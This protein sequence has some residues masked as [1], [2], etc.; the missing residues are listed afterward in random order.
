MR[1]RYLQLGQPGLE[2]ALDVPAAAG[3]LEPGADDLALDDVQRR[4]ALDIEPLCEVR[5]L[6]AVDAVELEGVVVLALL[7]HLREEA[8][9]AAAATGL[10]RVEEHEP[11]LV[12]RCGRDAQIEALAVVAGEVSSDPSAS[13]R[14]GCRCRT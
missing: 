6:L 5:M 3:L 13:R 4:D 7:E 11:W 1:A 2:K 12:P 10:G 9:D 14:V 8:V